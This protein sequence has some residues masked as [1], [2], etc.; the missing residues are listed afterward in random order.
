MGQEGKPFMYSHTFQ[1]E[2]SLQE[3]KLIQIPQQLLQLQSV[4]FQSFN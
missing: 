3:Q 4:S 1:R 2:E